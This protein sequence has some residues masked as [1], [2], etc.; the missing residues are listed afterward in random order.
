M[1]NSPS[2]KNEN[3]LNGNYEVYDRKHDLSDAKS[4]DGKRTRFVRMRSPGGGK[5]MKNKS[6]EGDKKV[7]EIGSPTLKDKKEKKN[8][9]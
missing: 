1:A 3:E 9:E 2:P 7:L 8:E 5:L 6:D 4:I